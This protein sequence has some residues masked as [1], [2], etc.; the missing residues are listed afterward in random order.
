MCFAICP[1]RPILTQG[2]PQVIDRSLVQL[3]PQQGAI[4]CLPRFVV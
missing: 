3:G 1:Q 4:G 2:E